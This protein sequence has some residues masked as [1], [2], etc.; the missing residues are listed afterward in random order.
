MTTDKPQL[1]ATEILQALSDLRRALRRLAIEPPDAIEFEPDAW[2][3]VV[4]LIRRSF[5]GLALPPPP[6]S[7]LKSLS[8]MG[9]EIRRTDASRPEPETAAIESLL[10]EKAELRAQLAIESKARD[11]LLLENET[12]RK[13]AERYRWLRGDACTDRS[14][15]WMQ[16]EVR[17]WRA[18]R[19]T[20]DLNRD[21]LD[22]A[23]DKAMEEKP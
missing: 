16:W 9:I 19:W 23:I 12:L 13:N 22:G 1:D 18:P 21:A 11:A 2:S 5:Q 17:Q 6:P 14:A 10:A 8:V 15:R 7:D 4:H 20:C 3:R